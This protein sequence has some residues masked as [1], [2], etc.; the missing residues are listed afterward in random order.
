MEQTGRGPAHHA[1]RAWDDIPRLC[2]F[3]IHQLPKDAGVMSYCREL[4][5]SVQNDKRQGREAALSALK[6][7]EQE[8]SNLGPDDWRRALLETKADRKAVLRLCRLWAQSAG[9]RQ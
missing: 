8:S 9:I 7:E 4:V 5:R 6:E 3:L 1:V 2:E